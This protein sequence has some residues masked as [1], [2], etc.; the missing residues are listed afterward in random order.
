MMR[1]NINNASSKVNISIRLNLNILIIL[2][3]T[4]NLSPVATPC[5]LYYSTIPM[6]ATTTKRK[7]TADM[8]DSPPK[9]VVTRARAAK[10]TDEKPPKPRTTKVATPSTKA[11]A[12][13]KKAALP[14]KAAAPPKVTKRKT[15]ADDEVA[16]TVNE[17]AVEE[18]VLEVQPPAQT[19]KVRGRP[20][21][22]TPMMDEDIQVVDAPKTRT[23][24]RK[25]PAT[26]KVEPEAP[27]T[28]GRL[29]KVA[30]PATV[31]PETQ[32]QSELVAPEPVKKTV[33]GRPATTAARII[34]RIAAAKVK[35]VPAKKKVKFEEAHDK[36]NLP[37]EATEPKK[38]ALKPTGLKAKPVRMPTSV[39]AS[40]T[41]GRKATR[42]PEKKAQ[43]AEQ[44]ETL[45]L[46]PKKV[47][48]VAKSD[49]ISEDELAGEKTPVRALSRSPAKRPM[50]PIKEMASVSKL[51][52]EQLAAPSSP[53]KAISSSVFTSPARR[54]PPS[55]FKESLKTSPQKLSLGDGI[56][57]PVLMSSR[58]PM[59]AS[60]MQE[61]PK[62]GILL[63]SVIKPVVL[64]M[65]SPMKSSL[66]QSPA[67]RPPNSPT[68]AIVRGSPDKSGIMEAA[69]DE[70]TSS[71]EA[72]PLQAR[73]FSDE[74]TTSSPF[75]SAR[76]P[77]HKFKIHNITNEERILDDRDNKES[78]SQFAEHGEPEVEAE[79]AV[80]PREVAETVDDSLKSEDHM[81]ME[82]PDYFGIMDE[83]AE[84]PAPQEVPATFAAPAF[85]IGSLS[86]RRTSIESEI[87]ED[88]L[89]S[90]QKFCQA[91]PLRRHDISPKVSGTP[92]IIDGQNAPQ[93]SNDN[94]SFT[95]LADQLSSWNAS[96]PDKQS[97]KPRRARGVFSLGGEEVHF[98]ADHIPAEAQT[99]TPAKFSFFDD[100]MA[101]HDNQNDTSCD[102]LSVDHPSD[103]AALQ[104]SQESIASD[105]YGDENAMPSNPESLRAGHDTDHTLT[106]TPAKVFTPVKAMQRPLEMHT[107]SKVP[108]R[109]SAEE[110]PL[111][112][113]R[114][115]SRSL[116]GPLTAV[117][118]P[119]SREHSHVRDEQSATPNLSPSLAP[120][121]PSSGMKLDAETPGRT[122]RKGIVPD[123]L[124]G[125][126]VYVD[127]HT[128]EGADASGI[129]VD[130]LTQMGARCVKQWNWN[131][132]ASMGSSLG[133]A[134][135]PQGTSPDVSANKIGITHVVYK[136]G[137][138]R[139]LEKVRSSNGVV[140]CVGVG[141]VLE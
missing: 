114:Q 87:S 46:S 101:M 8:P 33:R 138:K 111:I 28:R 56:A 61:T 41:R 124:K 69:N 97:R 92:T 93:P 103:V 53:A 13:K 9:R 10:G 60:L 84:S 86:L 17:A 75:R 47:L 76:S 27:K 125:A 73:R 4:L 30:E 126:V 71:I 115:R 141:W 36:E 123:V 113:A 80:F 122:V 55:P 20:K 43:E 100:Q 25:A 26:E 137:G 88:E 133:S 22:V 130:L 11:A 96:S 64:T 37:V 128:T 119:K 132:R 52:F 117:A 68:K 57:Q 121:T 44:K 2:Q 70:T 78:A 40:A 105:E 108:L 134:A 31:A 85:S 65:R 51:S 18:P 7:K 24:Q 34:P 104:V 79:T 106:C 39:R 94:L 116:G 102:E 35:T 58:T 98:V 66:L 112:P 89:A 131:P 54:P 67:R 42:G 81:S 3:T 49:P 63:N 48:Q 99:V 23:R 5:Q 62:R 91:T 74:Q 120:Q 45:P 32:A 77:E 109:P 139:T 136:D 50:S 15:R 19:T 110:F 16:E 135:S 83:M 140:L 127:V 21:K 107:V 95:P 129:F 59:K 14:A 118:Q 90:P 12:E 29:K 6:V 72:S 82:A 1:G 38:S